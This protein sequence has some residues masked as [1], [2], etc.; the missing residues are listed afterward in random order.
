MQ[1]LNLA[2][3]V[4]AWLQEPAAHGVPNGGVVL[5][6]DGA[7][8]VDSLCVA[9]QVEPFATE[10]EALGFPI[11]RL[12]LS[13]DHIEF[14]GGSSRFKLAA[15][16]G[17]ASASAHLD[18]PPTPAVYRALFPD[19]ANEFDDEMRT[20]PVSHVVAGATELT[21]ASVVLPLV[22]QSA[23]NLVVVVPEAGVLFAGAL[24]SFG[25]TPLAYDGDPSVWAET[26]DELGTLAP[27]I[28]PGHGPLG[29]AEEVAAQAAYLKACADAEG[30]PSRISAGPWDRWNGRQW[31]EVNVERA[32][33]LAAGG[34]PREPP[35]SMLRALGLR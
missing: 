29:G 3:G 2:P 25:V 21:P 18:Q 14:V 1:L 6:V 32:A 17:T 8:V 13:G 35:V 4:Y 23:E 9:S 12:V 5:D 16:Y 26:L 28:V 15:V 34:D 27:I 7:T 10:V 33:H 30:D 24:C 20:R 31:D 22:G 19:L 11:R